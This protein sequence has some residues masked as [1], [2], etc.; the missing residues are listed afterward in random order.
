VCISVAL[1]L[2]KEFV[3]FYV[4]F[5]ESI[6]TG[7]PEMIAKVMERRDQQNNQFRTRDIPRLLERL[8]T[9]PDFYVEMKWE[10]S[11][12]VPFVSRMCPNDT[13]CIWKKGATVRVDTTLLG[14]HNL[15]WQ[16]GNQSFVFRGQEHSAVVMEID[17]DKRTVREETIS[18][19]PENMSS[20]DKLVVTEMAVA[21]R[22]SSPVVN[23]TISTNKINFSRQ[24]SGIWGFRSERSE[25]VN[26][27]EAKVFSATGVEMVT[28]TRVEH[29]PEHLKKK[30]TGSFT[31]PIHSLFG[32]AQNEISNLHPPSITQNTTPPPSPSTPQLTATEYFSPPNNPEDYDTIG[33][34]VEEKVSVQTLK[35]SLWLAEDYPLTIEEQL[36]PIVDLLAITNSHFAKLREFITLQMPSGFPVRFEIPLFHVVSARVTFGNL[37]ACDTPAPHVKNVSIDGVSSTTTNTDTPLS[38]RPQSGIR[39]RHGNSTMATTEGLCEVPVPSSDVSGSTQQ[40]IIN[41]SCFSVPEDYRRVVSYAGQQPAYNEEELLQMA[42]EQSLLEQG[43]LEDTPNTSEAPLQPHPPQPMPRPS[44]PMP[45]QDEDDD[46]QMAMALSLQTLSV[47]DELKKR[48][49][50][51]LEMVLK[52]S[53]QDQ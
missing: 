27:V 35:A 41:D 53:L 14:F 43:P 26:G 31:T 51:E 29:L 5:N 16:R 23:T 37:N 48:E 24:K 3:L 7:S 10:F 50:D 33:R 36:L 32:A 38:S 44:Q 2:E 13:Y 1:V 25:K 11:S 47:N 17:H 49:E 12:W 9:S 18:L 30:A 46:L 8:E 6:C 34:P 39:K 20:A 15:S 22:L 40:C 21:A 19:R 52:L 28:R 45:R 4:V 42:I